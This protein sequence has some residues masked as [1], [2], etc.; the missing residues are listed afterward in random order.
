MSCFKETV[1]VKP[2]S[3]LAP[4][5]HAAEHHLQP[6]K[7]VLP[8]HNDHGPARGPALTGADGF[9]AGGSCFQVQ[10]S[11][12]EVERRR[13]GRDRQLTVRPPLSRRSVTQ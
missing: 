12:G 6:V 5:Q 7:E 8:D 13:A 2:H 11:G 10:G 4:H 9:D 1:T 3:Y